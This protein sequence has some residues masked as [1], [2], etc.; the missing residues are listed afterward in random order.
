MA[1]KAQK[2]RLAVFVAV[3]L[4]AIVS[5]A[6]M[7]TSRKFL[8]ERDVYKISYKN[9]SVSGLEVGS[10]VKYLGIRIGIIDDITIDRQDVGRILIT[11]ALKPDTPI[12]TDA[13]ADIA[14]V[15]ITG[16][17]A[18]EI[19]GGSNAAPLLKPGDL[20]RAGSSMTEEITGKAEVIA[21]K[22]E[23][24]LNNLQAFTQPEKLDHFV[25]LADRAG[26]AFE[27]ADLMLTDNRHELRQLLAHTNNITARLDTTS[28]LLHETIASLRQTIK[29]DTVR[30][31][32]ANTQAISSKLR[33]ADLV[34]LIGELREVTEQTNYSLRLINQGLERGGEDFISSMRQLR[35]TVDYLEETSRLLQQDPSVLLR[36]TNFTKTPDKFLDK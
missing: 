2:I 23:F 25:G 27:D 18:I 29:S 11:V 21:E 22:L 34:A 31:I 4:L 12:K 30:Q 19:R 17:K 14:A 35:L 9:I 15:G 6:I 7:F 36:G 24:V 20:I 13:Y 3:S 16:L 26:R 33:E 28:L 1:T 5:F 10:P 8:R 32:L